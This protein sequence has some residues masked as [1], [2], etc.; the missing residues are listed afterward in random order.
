MP[1]DAERDIVRPYGKS[2]RHTLVLS[3]NE[4]T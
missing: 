2:L 3:R 1:M 4:R